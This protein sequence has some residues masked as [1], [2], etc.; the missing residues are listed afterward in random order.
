MAD[1][2]SLR[3]RAWNTSFC[4]VNPLVQ[5]SRSVMYSLMVS[6]ELLMFLVLESKSWISVVKASLS[7][8]HHFVFEAHSSM[9][10]VCRKS[11]TT[12][13]FTAFTGKLPSCSPIHGLFM[14]FCSL[15][16]QTPLEPNFM[17]ETWGTTA[18]TDLRSSGIER[19]G[20][21]IVCHGVG[22]VSRHAWQMECSSYAVSRSVRQNFAHCCTES[23]G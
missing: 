11:H 4:I 19:K 14:R 2:S 1:F 22:C 17:Q 12:A 15:W 7:E 8:D 10:S 21:V 9:E 5:W 23:C 6:V 13:M 18:N 20:E 3:N 16:G